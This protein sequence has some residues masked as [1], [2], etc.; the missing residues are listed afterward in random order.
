MAVA[1]PGS[2]FTGWGGDD[3]DCALFNGQT[4]VIDMN[5]AKTVTA[6]FALITP[7][8]PL[9]VTTDGTGTGTVDGTGIACGTVC[10]ADYPDGTQ[11]TLTA[12]AGIDSTFDG[13][14]GDCAD[15][16]SRSPPAPSR[17][18]GRGR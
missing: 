8:D 2:I 16:V 5:G 18:T 6:T 14:G 1:D 9:N 11:L 4:C 13:W 12:T 15:R 17:W 7:V 10:S 3:G